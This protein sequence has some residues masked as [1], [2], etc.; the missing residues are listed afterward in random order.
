MMFRY[1]IFLLILAGC[2]SDTDLT[3]KGHLPDTSTDG[4]WIFLVPL[5]NASKER[6]DSVMI[7]NGAFQF[8][9][10]AEVPEIYIIRAKPVLRLTLQELLVVK[11]PGEL[12]VNIGKNSS[13]GGT[14]LNDSL[15]HWKETK[16]MADYLHEELWQK[17]KTAD[18]AEQAVIKQKSDSLNA[19]MV[20]F[21]YDFVRR[22]QDNIVGKFVNKM[23]GD[24]FSPEQKKSLN[25]K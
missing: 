24:S 23:I 11:E 22:N 19:R 7:A 20:D 9:E 10:S 4:A 12:I 14:V 13:A 17:L 18:V 15:Q 6:V 5:E 3:I 21:H 1:L 16:M 8:K 25:L 2:Q